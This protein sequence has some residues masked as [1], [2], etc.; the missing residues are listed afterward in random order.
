MDLRGWRTGGLGAPKKREAAAEME[1]GPVEREGW[2][3]AG[4][5]EK[6]GDENEL[7][8]CFFLPSSTLHLILTR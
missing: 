5:G 6:G 2:R 3:K 1:I 8:F 4:P 7:G